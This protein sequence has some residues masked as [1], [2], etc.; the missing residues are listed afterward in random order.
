MAFGSFHISRAKWL[1]AIALIAAVAIADC[2]LAKQRTSKEVKREKQKTEKQIAQTKKQIDEND[3]ETGRQ[4]KRLESIKADIALRGDTIEM[5]RAKLDSV[6]GAISEMNDSI[7]RLEFRE[8]A[9]RDNYARSLRAIRSRRQSMNDLSFIFSAPTFSQAWRR[10]R[11]LREVAK[12]STKQARQ[13][14][15]A[16]RDVDKA[17]EELDGLRHKQSSALGRH[18]A[19]QNTLRTE[20]ASADNIIKNL[21]KQG[22]S[23]QRELEKRNRQAQSLERELDKIVEQ[24]IR[25]AEER[26]RKEAAEAERRRKE[27]EAKARAEAE[28][29]KKAE[30]EAKARAEA[31]AKARAEAEAKKKQQAAGVSEPRKP[32]PQPQ[33]SAEPK[34][35]QEEAASAAAKS[36][37]AAPK[38]TFES[39]AEQD[40]RLTGSFESNKGKLLFPVAGRYTIVSNFGTNEFPELSKVMVDNLGID[41]EVPKGSNARSIFEGIV[42]SIFRLEG[43]NNIV[44]VR[45]GEYLSVYAGIDALAVKKGDKVASGQKL[46]TLSA[47]SGDERS[48]LHFEIRHEKQKLNP[49]EWVR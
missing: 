5:L 44:I 31:E 19:V 27:A 22:A 34:K 24:E 10:V 39:E 28:A 6:N 12:S 11:Y 13:I 45:H 35:P 4:L 38:P 48:R 16:K 33:A 40:R 9:L 7:E 30:M 15:K 46:G 26:K 1:A 20:Q 49:T 37:A 25:E 3:R 29:K 18:R 47:P 14:A 32:A 36:Q 42:S 2:A 17:R 8:T 43:Y 21:K 41:I 23:L